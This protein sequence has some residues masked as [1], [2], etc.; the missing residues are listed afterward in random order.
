MLLKSIKSTHIIWISSIL[1][2]TISLHSQGSHAVQLTSQKAFEFKIQIRR[3]RPHD[4]QNDENYQSNGLSKESEA[5]DK[6]TE[7][8]SGVDVASVE[9]PDGQKGENRNVIDQ[10]EKQEMAPEVEKSDAMSEIDKL[11]E[12]EKRTIAELEKQNG[13][14]QLTEEQIIENNKKITGE[15]VSDIDKVGQMNE[16]E[17]KE[18]LENFAQSMA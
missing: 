10:Q 7:G 4:D 5:K 13:G 11:I 1:L 2:I 15:V 8:Q 17:M 3:L 9:K 12:H 16:K 18:Q 6:E 14:S